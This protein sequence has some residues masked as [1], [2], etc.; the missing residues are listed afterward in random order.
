MESGIEIM[1]IGGYAR[2][3]ATPAAVAL[4][5]GCRAVTAGSALVSWVLVGYAPCAERCRFGLLWRG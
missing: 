1:H 3:Q 2:A 4:R 5:H